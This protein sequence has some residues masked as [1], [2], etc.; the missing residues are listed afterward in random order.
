MRRLYL[1][2]ALC[3]AGCTPRLPPPDVRQHRYT[4]TAFDSTGQEVG[5]VTFGEYLRGGRI[6]VTDSAS[7]YR[8]NL[9][10]DLGLEM[11]D[12]WAGPRLKEP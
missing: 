12:S 9:S 6:V 8:L 1:T 4:V 10:P 7:D 3:V 11:L 5:R 2:L